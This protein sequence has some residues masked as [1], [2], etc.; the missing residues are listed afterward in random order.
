MIYCFSV[1]NGLK[2]GEKEL[3][4][5]HIWCS[6]CRHYSSR[7]WA[8]RMS[9]T[10]S[11]KR[12]TTGAKCTQKIS[13]RSSSFV[14]HLVYI[15][16][17]IFRLN[18]QCQ[19]LCHPS[20]QKIIPVVVWKMV[21]CCEKVQ[22]QIPSPFKVLKFAPLFYCTIHEWVK[23]SALWKHASCPY[24]ACFCCWLT[25][26]LSSVKI[27]CVYLTAHHGLG[28][29][30]SFCIAITRLEHQFGFEGK[31]HG[32][33]ERYSSHGFCQWSTASGQVPRTSD[34][35]GR[36]YW[37]MV[38]CWVECWVQLSQ[39]Q[40]AKLMLTHAYGKREPLFRVLRVQELCE[41][42]GGRHGLP[43]PNKPTA[44]VDVKQHSAM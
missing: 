28:F 17:A 43:V 10:P 27:E 44:S 40:D 39:W 22:K 37:L 15:V 9:T 2:F 26:V 23:H 31:V 7:W 5:T 35:T 16:W 41:S 32:Q 25:A 11:S 19:F 34:G 42:R 38:P 24:A 36:W 30:Y 3:I 20:L 33:S 21:V 1:C 12:G 18:D 6:D 8:E 13:A 14:S 4:L 29:E